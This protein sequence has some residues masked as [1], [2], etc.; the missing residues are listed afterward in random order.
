MGFSETTRARADLRTRELCAGFD[1]YLDSFDRQERFGGP[2]V[3]FHQRTIER[4]RAL[5]SPVAAGRD[6]DFCELLYATLTAWG[7]HQGN[8]TKSSPCD[9]QYA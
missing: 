8:R 6:R 7:M 9:P 5:G 4:R 2:S 1:G 3:H